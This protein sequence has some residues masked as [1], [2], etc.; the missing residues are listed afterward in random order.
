MKPILSVIIPVYNAEKYI[1]ETISSLL[2]QSL[3]ELEII[4]VDD[5]SSDRSVEII[6]SYMKTERR[7]ILLSQKHKNAGPARNAG[8]KIAKG[9]YIHF[10]DAD[11]YVINYGYETI[12][13]KCIKNRLECIKFG[14]IRFDERCDYTVNK[15]KSDFGALSSD[16]FGIPLNYH[17]CRALASVN[18][19]PWSG[20]YLRSFLIKNNIEFNDLVCVN[21][22]SF[23]KKI[24]VNCQRMM[25][26]KDMVVV[27][28]LNVNNSLINRRA[29]NFECQYESIRIIEKILLDS[30]LNNHEFQELLKD[31]FNDMFYWLNRIAFDSPFKQKA[32]NITKQTIQ[33][34]SERYQF[35]NPYFSLYKE[36]VNKKRPNKSLSVNTYFKYYYSLCSSPT[37]SIHIDPKDDDNISFF[38]RDLSAI[39]KDDL[40]FIFL[41]DH[42]S[43]IARSSLNNYMAFDHRFQNGKLRDADPSL[44]TFHVDQKGRIKL[45][46]KKVTFSSIKDAVSIGIK[47]FLSLRTFYSSDK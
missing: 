7:I 26:S 18:A 25:V 34:F 3:N 33:E 47:L 22:R 5:G 16:E 42:P 28:R 30:Q 4:F 24:L 46:M 27:H 43:L 32:L 10:L 39:K 29:E 11:D 35:I 1:G 6:R 17:D 21:D 12:I 44:T 15:E 37:V 19:T 20:V 41:W 36:V 2:N 45:S 13:K 38:L 9:D 31:E 8:L 40:S 14:S 23:F